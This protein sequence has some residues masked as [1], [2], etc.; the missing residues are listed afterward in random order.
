LGRS[1]GWNKLEA[2][3]EGIKAGHEENDTV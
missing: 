2:Y 3:D 1:S